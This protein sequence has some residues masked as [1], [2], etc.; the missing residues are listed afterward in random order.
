MTRHKKLLSL[1]ECR[2][3]G[4]AR[5]YLRT[6]ARARARVTRQVLRFENFIRITLHKII[7]RFFLNP[8]VLPSRCLHPPY[9]RAREST[10]TTDAHT[11]VHTRFPSAPPPLPTF[12]LE[13][14]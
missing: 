2:L 14:G 7:V 10:K 12:P 5:A 3:C 4:F 9:V 11:D 8:R 13:G 1:S 6:H